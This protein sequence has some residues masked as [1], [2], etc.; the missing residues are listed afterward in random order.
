MKSDSVRKEKISIKLL[1]ILSF[2][3]IFLVAYLLTGFIVFSGWMSSVRG[4]IAENERDLSKEIINQI[5]EYVGVPLYINEVNEKIIANKIVDLTNKDERERFFAGVMQAHIFDSLYSFS[6]GT[7]RGEYYGARKNINDEIELMLNDN[8]TDGNSWYYSVNDSLT[9]NELATKAG[10]F[11]PRTRA[12]YISAEETKGPVFAP[13]YKHFVMDDLTL[14]AALP[15]YDNQG[16]F[17]GV[18]GSHITLGRINQFL[19]DITENHRSSAIIIEKNS[20]ELI[21]NSLGIVNYKEDENGTFKNKKIDEIEN[22]FILEAY[23]EYKNSGVSNIKRNE[24]GENHYINFSGFSKNGIEW[25]IIT[26]IP[27]S[28][29]T[30]GILKNIIGSGFMAIMAVILAILLYFNL[31][32]RYFLPIEN[33]IET[34]EKYSKGDFESRAKVVRNDEIGKLALAFNLMADALNRLIGNLESLVKERTANLEENKDQLR[35]ILDSTVEAIYGID[36]KGNCTFCNSRCLKLLGYDDEKELL[37]KN[38]HNQIHHSKLNGEKMEPSECKI[39]MGLSE[40]KGVHSADEVFWRAD[41]TYIEV[42][43][44]SYPQFKDGEVVGA[45]I[46]FMDNSLEKKTQE[47]IKFLSYHDSLTGLYNR[48]FFEEEMIRL[49]SE[50]SLPI[51]IIFADVNGLKLTNDIF[52]HAV[53][54]RLLEKSAEILKQVCRHEDIIARVGGDEFAILLPSTGESETKAIISRI[55]EVMASEKIAAIKCSMAMGFSTKNNIKESLE[56]VMKKA[57]DIMYREKTMARKNTNTQLLNTIIETLHERS[58]KEKEHSAVVSELCKKIAE[59]L[60]MDQNDVRK[61]KEAGF[62]HDLGK[63]VFKKE[64]L[65]KEEY[66]FTEEEDKEFQQHSVIGYRILNL[67]DETL[68]LAEGVLNHHENWDGTGFPKGLKGEEIPLTA[69]IIAIAEAYDSMTNEILSER[70]TKEEAI[71]EL[72]RLKGI[73]FDPRI[74]EILKKVI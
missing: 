68:D 73:R 56:E 25:L 20:G 1:I 21:A 4:T 37:G 64:L 10:K 8:T 53:G 42:E 13:V 18:L 55:N 52:G 41:G 69:R 65:E 29:F 28:L 51:S 3:T 58:P 63:I 2:I 30:Q 57:E 50:R 38:M 14:S 44:H 71:A 48:M 12:W 61:V 5:D 33:L 70:K 24:N 26:D 34:T 47:R 72:E 22:K 66:N 60:N 62:I 17:L 54:D 27:E 6:F 11:D 46:T 7:V 31:I 15:V 45:V 39:F 59:E 40:K 74:V 19:E 23:S 49:D 9:A 16:E 67:F 32:K 35:L 43:Y 36:L